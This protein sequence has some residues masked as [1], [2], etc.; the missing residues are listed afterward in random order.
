MGIAK[1]TEWDNASKQINITLVNYE[2]EETTLT[3][4]YVNGIL[5]DKIASIP[6]VLSPNQEVEITLS[7]KYTIMPKQVTIE[8]Q[9][10]NYP[11]RGRW[12]ATFIDLRL[13]RVYWDE[14]TG[15]IRVLLE[16]AGEYSEVNFSKVYVNGTLD[17]AA[18]VPRGTYGGQARYPIYEISLSG[19]YLS[20]PTAMLLK[21]NTADG[22]SFELESPF[23]EIIN[24][25]SI[26]WDESTGRIKF[27]VYIPTAHFL[28]KDIDITFD[29]IYVNGTLSDVA[30]ISRVYSE[31]YE[32]VL[33]KSYE[34]CPSHATIKVV[35]D[36]GAFCERTDY[37][38][39][40]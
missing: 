3:A 25:F 27:F 5:D 14:S 40:Y 6:Q 28:E 26:Q 15:R 12:T 29:E 18:V 7:E 1:S 22:N 34:N 9:A 38:L 20:K 30:F 17:D 33:S 32:I 4:I 10:E 35:T 39:L 11:W 16:N 19:I 24:L 21:I 23:E 13:L 31:T 8:V 36:F 37:N 2:D